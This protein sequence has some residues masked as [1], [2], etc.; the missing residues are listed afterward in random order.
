[1]IRAL[2]EYAITFRLGELLRIPGEESLT[3]CCGAV[4]LHCT[5]RSYEFIKKKKKWAVD[6]S[7]YPRSVKARPGL[8]G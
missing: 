6:A 4:T 8:K 7:R 2:G 1:M 5:P 3:T